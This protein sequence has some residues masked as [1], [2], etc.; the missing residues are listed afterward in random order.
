MPGGGKGGA[1]LCVRDDIFSPDPSIHD[2][3]GH[4]GA[5]GHGRRR[6]ALAPLYQH[7]P[8]EGLP[9]R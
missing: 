3:P 2:L 4:T 6:V 5:G 7:C 8:Q 1:W 9:E